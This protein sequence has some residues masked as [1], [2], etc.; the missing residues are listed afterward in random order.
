MGISSCSYNA[1]VSRYTEAVNLRIA[2]WDNFG[3]YL[4]YSFIYKIYYSEIERFM[5]WE[6][7]LTPEVASQKRIFWSYPPVTNTTG[8]DP[9]FIQT[10]KKS[11]F[12]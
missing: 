5:V 2:K 11:I 10:M 8:I 4:V 7:H 9:I 6:K 1:F 12:N 3:I